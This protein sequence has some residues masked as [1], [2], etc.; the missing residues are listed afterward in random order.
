MQTADTT[1]DM[2][3]LA[4]GFYF[5]KVKTAAATYTVRIIKK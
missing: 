4:D 5:V 2:T 1:I 3:S